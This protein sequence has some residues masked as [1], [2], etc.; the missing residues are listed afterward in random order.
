MKMQDPGEGGENTSL[1]VLKKK[2]IEFAED[3][4]NTSMSYSSYIYM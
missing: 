4:R 1:D 2:K 3:S